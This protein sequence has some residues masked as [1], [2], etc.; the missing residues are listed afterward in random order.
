ML[1]RKLLQLLGCLPILFVLVLAGNNGWAQVNQPA[2]G[3]SP[4]QAP[5]ALNQGERVLLVGNSLFENDLPYGYLEMA[6]T[7][8]WP[9]RQVTFRNIGWSGDNV[10]GA[11][12]GTITNPPTPYE[13]LMEQITKAKPTLVFM[14]YGGIEAEEGETGLPGFTE[15]M[16]KL[17]DTVNQLGAGAVLL[18]PI[19]VFSAGSPENTARRNA[20][21]ELYT[22]AIARI[23]SERGIRYVDLFTPMQQISRQVAVSDNGIHLNETGYYYLASALEAGLGLPPRQQTISL[24]LGKQGPQ[25]SGPVKWLPTG[26]GN[27]TLTFTVN[28]P[29][30]PLPLPKEGGET[31]TGAVLTI[32]GLTKGFYT[33]TADGAQLVTASASQWAK[34]VAIQHGPLYQQARQLQAMIRKKNDLYFQ[35][36]RPQNHT[37]IIGFRSYEQGRHVKTLDDLSFII[38]WL[39]GQIALHR[40][41]PIPVY[42]LSQLK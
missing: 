4:V 24:Q 1:N 23:A 25:V 31:A 27:Q 12:R 10:F 26:Q 30:L 5:F 41:P 11:A 37:Y 39:D 33:L 3:R 14:A 32:S 21:M 29:Y 36:Y 40:T 22:A 28:E 35:Q 17:I 34:G 6:L 42:Q 8:R 19:P 13:V 15:G 2:S 38:T 9:D 16:N 20:Q 18:S 7:T